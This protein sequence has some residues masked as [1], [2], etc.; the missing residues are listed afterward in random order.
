[1][2]PK[3]TIPIP[4]EYL[5]HKWHWGVY[6]K[7]PLIFFIYSTLEKVLSLLFVGFRNKGG[8]KNLK[9]MSNSTKKKDCY[10]K[11]IQAKEILSRAMLE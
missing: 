2:V 4:I 5:S 7:C 6:F 1:M 11:M 8:P 10:K 9:K 3:S